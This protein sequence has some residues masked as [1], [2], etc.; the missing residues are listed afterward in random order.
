MVLDIYDNEFMFF[1]IFD[2][3]SKNKFR[4]AFDKLEDLEVRCYY[5]LDKWFDFARKNNLKKLSLFTQYDGPSIDCLMKI[6]S[7]WPNLVELTI[8]VDSLSADDIV[9]FLNACKHL[10]RINISDV[11]RGGGEKIQELKSKLQQEFK[12]VSMVT[13]CYYDDFEHSIIRT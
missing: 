1:E 2:R 10:Q 4:I 5:L 13:K 7:N 9:Q 11:S 6:A 3:D 12:L 8:Q